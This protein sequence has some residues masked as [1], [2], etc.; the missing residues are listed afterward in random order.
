MAARILAGIGGALWLLAISV[1]LLGVPLLVALTILASALVVGRRGRVL[2]RGHAWLIA[3]FSAGVVIALGF[4]A[5]LLSLP[6]AERD[7]MSTAGSDP[8]AAPDLPDWL[9]RLNQRSTQGGGAG[10]DAAA[11]RLAE[12]KPFQLYITIFTAVVLVAFLGAFAGSLTW[13]GAGLL[14]LAVRGAWFP[15]GER[16]PLP[17]DPLPSPFVESTG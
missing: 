1:G 14:R 8:A 3:F 17:G 5:L 10:G 11:A 4:G 2:S 6:A 16:K 13:L 7:R 9:E 15:P 12:S